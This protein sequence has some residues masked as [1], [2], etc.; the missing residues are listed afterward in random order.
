MNINKLA[1][2]RN[3][4]GANDPDVVAMARACVD[5][6][7]DSLSLINTLVGMAIDVKTRRPVLAKTAGPSHR[8]ATTG[9]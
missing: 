7:A 1:T 9:H 5:A 6:G 4:R 2:I 3:A 8:F